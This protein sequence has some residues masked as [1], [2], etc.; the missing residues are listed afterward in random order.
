MLTPGGPLETPLRAGLRERHKRDKRQRIR[1]AARALFREKGFAATTTREI[2]AHA[3]IATGTLF[4]YARNKRELLFLLLAEGIE[5]TRDDAL[6]SV[7]CDAPIAE[8]LVHVF[9]CFFDHWETDLELSRELMRERF[10]VHAES[11]EISA[12][13]DAL[14]TGF[15]RDLATLVAAAQQRGELRRDFDPQIAAANAFASY[16]IQLDT[17]LF[18]PRGPRALHLGFLRCSVELQLQGL[19][20]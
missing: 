19:V 11:P 20:A 14:T 6:G 8:Q 1:Q 4:R 5:R 3:G 12:A 9:A 7:P 18:S 15:I 13:I 2:S 17:W 16:V 10:H